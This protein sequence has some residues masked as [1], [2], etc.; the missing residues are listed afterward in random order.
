[1]AKLFAQF[2]DL[3]LILECEFD[4]VPSGR[5]PNECAESQLDSALLIK[6]SRDH[7]AAAFF[8][9]ERAFTKIRRA[10]GPAVFFAGQRR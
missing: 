9:F 10:D 8:F 5:C 2:H 7:F 4:P 1:M 3:N 6:K